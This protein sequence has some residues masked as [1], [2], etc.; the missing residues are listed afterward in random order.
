M[1]AVATESGCFFV[2]L[3]YRPAAEA[4]IITDYTDELTAADTKDSGIVSPVSER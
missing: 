2:G 1:T 4:A 3:G